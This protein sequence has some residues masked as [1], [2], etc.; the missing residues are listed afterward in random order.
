MPQTKFGFKNML[1]GIAEPVLALRKNLQVVYCN[2]AY[3]DLVELPVGELEGSN[4][5][6]AVPGLRDTPC[7]NTY[8]EVLATGEI[9]QITTSYG[10]RYFR[11]RVYGTSW[12][13]VSIFQDVTEDERIHRLQ[14][15]ESGDFRALLEAVNDALLIHDAYTGEIILA[16]DK[17]SE[18]FV[19]RREQLLGMNITDLVSGQVPYTKEE[20][21]Q[22]IKRAFYSQVSP[23]EWEAKDKGG[24]TFW[25]KVKPSRISMG[26]DERILTVIQ[27]VTEARQLKAALKESDERYRNLFDNARDMIFAHDLEGNFLFVNRAAEK[28]TGYWRDELLKMNIE[29]LVVHDYSQLLRS[30][31]YRKKTRQKENTY[32][33][34]ISTKYQERVVLEISA[35]P[36]YKMGKPVA[37]QGIARDITQR[38][39]TEAA[40]AESE[41]SA[42]IILDQFPDAVLAINHEGKVVIWN[43]AMEE[44]TGV[45]AEEMLGKGDYEYGIPFYGIKRPLMVDVVLNPEEVAKYYKIFQYENYNLISEFDV[46]KLKGKAQY[47]W[48]TA[49]PLRNNSGSMIGAVESLREI[50]AQR[51][52]QEQKEAALR[53]EVEQLTFILNSIGLPVGMCNTQ[54]VI[55]LANRAFEEKLG[56]DHGELLEKGVSSLLA[57]K[58]VSA[59]K[60]E[61]A[62]RLATGTEG[63]YV[64][65]LKKKDG[66]E[67]QMKVKTVPVEQNGAVTKTLILAQFAG[68]QVGED[69]LDGGDAQ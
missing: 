53:G 43:K 15:R 69:G 14:T 54:G 13:L 32:E 45:K 38:K 51:K 4:L 40:L 8:L 17:A 49:A 67:L 56:Y 22:L 6:D 2:Q 48:G 21:A 12:G 35:W 64:L 29:Q 23:F 68:E 25:I 52:I 31:I 16:N 19:Y 41:Y 18:M 62:R 26:S 47:L 9:K 33:L 28:I 11:E 37:I 20:F 1:D 57:E 3:A 30:M 27:D 10:Y 39:L 65:V 7:H 46:P 50:T 61:L 55:A 5:F 60:E 59:P 36:V 63:E 34:E 66:T 42:R 58:Q 24:R 44:M